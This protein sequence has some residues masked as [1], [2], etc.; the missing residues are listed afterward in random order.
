MN[1]FDKIS[2]FDDDFVTNSISIRVSEWKVH[3]KTNKTTLKTFLSR[4][5]ENECVQSFQIL[6]DVSY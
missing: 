2:N 1:F 6:F 3:G 4:I 5:S